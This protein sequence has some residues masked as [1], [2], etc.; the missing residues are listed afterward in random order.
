M[1]SLVVCFLVLLV[2]AASSVPHGTKPGGGA[3]VVL[4]DIL[5]RVMEDI[6]LKHI[7]VRNGGRYL[8]I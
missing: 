3:E 1:A 8:S 7:R 6:Q 4:K 5:V 2:N